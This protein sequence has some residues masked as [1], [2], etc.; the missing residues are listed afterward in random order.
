MLATGFCS[1]AVWFSAAEWA[2][3]ALGFAGAAALSCAM[4]DTAV[5][6]GKMSSQHMY[7]LLDG[8][9]AWDVVRVVRTLRAWS[10]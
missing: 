2:T 5:K 3:G 4:Y 9:R 6:V 7:S 1:A 10:R 8:R